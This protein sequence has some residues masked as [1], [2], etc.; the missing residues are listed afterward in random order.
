[1]L[2]T[3]ELQLNKKT[4]PICV[5]LFIIAL[6]LR[7]YHL[8]YQSLWFEELMTLKYSSGKSFFEFLT[9]YINHPDFHPPM[10]PII[11]YGW[12]FLGGSSD[13]WLKLPS[14]LFGAGSVVL[15]Y[16]LGRKIFDHSIGLFAALM[17]AFSG[18]NIYYAQEVRY[19]TSLIFWFLLLNYWVFSLERTASYKK[20]IIL[21]LTGLVLS[22][23]HYSG[24]ILALGTLLFFSVKKGRTYYVSLFLVFLGFLPWIKI[25]QEQSAV[26]SIYRLYNQTP[27]LGTYVL[28]MLDF[29]FVY[30]TYWQGMP[31][32]ISPINLKI[33]FYGLIAFILFFKIHLSLKEKLSL[34]KKLDIIFYLLIIIFGSI[35]AF[36]V[37]DLSSE[38]KYFYEKALLYTLPFTYI[39]FAALIFSTFKNRNIRFSLSFLIVLFF[40]FQPFINQNYYHHIFKTEFRQ[41]SEFVSISEPKAPVFVLCGDPA[42]YEH[43][44]QKFNIQATYGKVDVSKIL[45]E[46]GARKFWLVSAH[47]FPEAHILNLPVIKSF[48]EHTLVKADL[49]WQK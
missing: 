14:V 39:L 46:M 12:K 43:Y 8:D 30:E 11:I 10:Y 13:W 3:T 28:K 23:T 1:M 47:C 25:I 21:T 24:F 45:E 29:S 42:W 6:L 37:H 40:I 26:W 33:F 4:W 2:T 48:N 19:G 31:A 17:M 41:M 27:H 20:V 18:A 38:K 7:L 44:F 34:P 35:L 49:V 32:I 5:L 9:S 15:T 22:Y 16:L 36:F